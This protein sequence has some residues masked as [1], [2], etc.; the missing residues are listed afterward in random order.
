MPILVQTP[1]PELG[2]GLG[3]LPRFRAQLGPFVGLS[4]AIRV[5]ALTRGFG[6]TQNDASAV[7]GLEAAFRVGVGL[8]CVLDESSDGLAFAQVGGREHTHTTGA[9]APPSQRSLHKMATRTANG[10]IVP[11]QDAVALNS[12]QMDLPVF[13]YRIFHIF[14]LNQSSDLMIQPYVGFDR[15]T[16]T[17]VVSPTGAPMPHLQTIVT[18]GS[19]WSSTGDIPEMKGIL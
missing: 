11:W 6:T 15:P 7:G 13:E 17:S 2:A 10:G 19:D 5:G 8:D 12:F 14:S 9:A 18:A 1:V 16:K 4:T 3:E